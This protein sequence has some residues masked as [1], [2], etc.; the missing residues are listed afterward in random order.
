VYGFRIG[1]AG[2]IEIEALKR[3]LRVVARVRALTRCARQLR[4]GRRPRSSCTQSIGAGFERAGV[5]SPVFDL[6]TLVR[7]AERDVIDERAQFLHSRDG[8]CGDIRA[9]ELAFDVRMQHKDVEEAVAARTPERIG[10]QGHGGVG[11]SAEPVRAE[12]ACARNVY[13]RP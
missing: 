1:R 4:R 6:E 12:D 9:V 5:E 13:V 2:D 8:E 7:V 10:E 11:G 3:A